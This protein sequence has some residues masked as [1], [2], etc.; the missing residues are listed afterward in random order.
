MTT[1]NLTPMRIEE[2]LPDS[3]VF[4]KPSS[5]G[6]G[7]YISIRT[8]DDKKV[9]VQTPRVD[10][11][12]CH[13]WQF[14]G[15]SHS[16]HYFVFSCPPK[17]ATWCQA[18]E[19][20]VLDEAIKNATAWFGVP[21]DPALVQTW[22]SSGLKDGCQMRLNVPF[23][24]DDACVAFFDKDKNPIEFEYVPQAG[25]AALLMELDGVWFRNKRFGLSW[26]LVQVR[27]YSNT[28]KYAF[29]PDAE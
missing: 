22:F 27:H 29:L 5:V 24:G 12:G 13:A 16:K 10:T 21:V 7:Q 18:V 14:D 23:R 25:V 19:R 20:R 11:L 15:S 8:A 9:V 6:G 3:L 28:H 4:K 2:V 17:L 26:K 1:A